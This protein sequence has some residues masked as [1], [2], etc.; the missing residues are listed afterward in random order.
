MAARAHCGGTPGDGLAEGE[1]ELENARAGA[2]LGEFVDVGGREGW[3]GDADECGDAGVEERAV[4]GW[5]VGEVLDLGVEDDAAAEGVEIAGERVGDGLAAACG[6]G[7]ACSVAGGGEDEASG[8]AGDSREGK[9]GVRG[10]AGEESASALV[11]EEG[12][13]EHLR[14]HQRGGAEDRHV[15]GV[16]G[17]AQERLGEVFDELRPVAN[18]GAEE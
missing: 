6:D 4:G 14:G 12:G 9:D 18:G 5:E 11:L 10:N 8:G 1:V 7:P 3:A 17:E 2:E 15:Y 16:A 13:G